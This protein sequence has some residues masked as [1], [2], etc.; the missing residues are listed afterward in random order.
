MFGFSLYPGIFQGCVTEDTV[1]LHCMLLSLQMACALS[2]ID[3]GLEVDTVVG[4]SFGQLTALCIAGSIGLEDTFRLVAGRAR[5]VRDSWG[6]ECGSMMALECDNIELSKVIEKVNSQ[7]NLRV[8]VACYN[9]PRSFVLAG[10]AAS[11]SRASEECRGFK[12]MSLQNDHAYHSHLADSILPSLKKVAETIRIQ[13]PRIRIETCTSAT[14]WS[15]FGPEQIVEHTRRPVY[16]DEA[17]SRIATRLP[18]AVWLEVGSATPV[19][20]MIQ[21]VLDRPSRSDV[22]I[23]MRIGNT[24]GATANLASATCKLWNAGLTAQYWLFHRS[25]GYRYQ[26][27]NLPPYQFEKSSHWLPFELVPILS[28]P[29]PKKTPAIVEL[30]KSTGTKSGE[31]VFVVDTQSAMFQLA[32]RGHAV[33]GQSLCPAS[34]YMEMVA[35][36]ADLISKRSDTIEYLPYLK[37]LIISAP[38]GVGDSSVTIIHLRKGGEEDTWD[39]IISSRTSVKS[40]EDGTRYASGSFGWQ[41]ANHTETKKRFKLLSRLGTYQIGASSTTTGI[42]GSMVYDC[43]GEVVEYADYYRGVHSVS[44]SGNKA[45]GMVKLPLERPALLDAGICDPIILD[46]FLQVAGIHCNSLSNRDKSTVLMCTSIDE[47]ILSPAFL[48]DKSNAREWTVYTR[49]EEGTP[50]T[51]TNDLFV[52]DVKSGDMV[53]AVIG[54]NFHGVAFKS[55]VKSLARRNR[56]TVATTN[57]S[58]RATETPASSIEV[59]EVH[60]SGYSS[61][62][63]SGESKPQSPRAEVLASLPSQ[64]GNISSKAPASYDILFKVRTMFS[65]IIE[66]PVEDITSA[67]TLDALGIDSLLV[68]EVLVELSSR[69]GMPVSQQQFFECSD[70]LAVANLVGCVN[71]AMATVSLTGEAVREST[72][73]TSLSA[74]TLAVTSSTLKRPDDILSAIPSN[75]YEAGETTNLASAA[76]EAFTQCLPSYDEHADITKFTG[77]YEN[78]YP[79]QSELVVMYVLEAFAKL[80]CDLRRLAPNDALPSFQHEE[81]HSK[82]VTQLHDILVDAGLVATAHSGKYLR[83]QKPLPTSSPVDL[84]DTILRKFPQHTSETKLLRATAHRLAECLNGAENP[85][86]LIFQNAEARALLGDVY[87][88]APMFKTGTLQLTKYLDSILLNMKGKRKLK[89]LELGAGTGGTTKTVVETLAKH[90][91]NFTYTFTDLSSSLV[92]QARR[93]FSN[94]NFMEFVVVDIEKDPKPEFLATYDI[95]LSTNCIHATRDLVH[96][97][98]NIRKMLKPDGLLCLVEL[99]RNLY[100]FDLVFGLLEGWWLF[101]D[102]RQHALATE[103]QW[104][105]DLNSAGFRWVDWSRSSTTESELLRVITASAIEPSPSGNSEELMLSQTIPFKEVNGLQLNADLYYPNERLDAG[106]KLPVGETP[107]KT[108]VDKKSHLTLSVQPS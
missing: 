69:F 60:D 99:T 12:T 27:L 106:K 87:T 24:N 88:N 97:T 104:Q 44:A 42:S 68:T 39:F 21:R 30:V 86:S 85:V 108:F 14:S 102:G 13:P 55:L 15:Q 10:N 54:A 59:G 103:Q 67:T 63:T 96:S 92:A 53:V 11:I 20:S 47:I 40:H 107:E 90:G 105:R 81:R 49:F 84:T 1:S 66:I 70:V 91:A 34:M 45:I 17:I 37:K 29:G 80:G 71:G 35:Q 48:T 7:N 2:W 72:L 31:Y 23:P 46:N 22:F 6:P 83:T 50:N 5:L 8:E 64:L 95:V 3:S 100:W 41:K 89:I 93:K 32:A 101:S 76:L 82:V 38:L 56:I 19:I 33:T 9:G 61:D 77:F 57:P 4:H 18:S 62:P 58:S 98:T 78:V 26:N 75:S 36:S 65:E 43:F 16:F 74:D 94:W 28:S 51:R 52:F 25:S 79:I 73:A